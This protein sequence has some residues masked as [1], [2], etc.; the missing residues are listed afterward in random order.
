MDGDMLPLGE[1]VTVAKRHKALLMVDEAYSLGTLR[2]SGRGIWEATDVDPCT[3]DIW[4]G[5]L[6]K[7][8]AAC[9]GFVTGSQALVDLLKYSAP[10]F[11]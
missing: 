6:S 7:T 3:V 8:L 4:M 11:V 5:T 10:G 9:G 2:P 1:I